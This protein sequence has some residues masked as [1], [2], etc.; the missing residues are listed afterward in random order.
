MTEKNIIENPGGIPE[1][2]SSYTEDDFR[3]DA[4]FYMAERMTRKLLEEDLISN[5]ECEEILKEHA[6][7]FSHTLAPLML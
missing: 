7:N 5:E 1:G 2:K 3:N 6:R 4:N